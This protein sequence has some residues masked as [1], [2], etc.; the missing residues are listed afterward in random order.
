MDKKAIYH[1]LI[2]RENSKII[3]Q[4]LGKDSEKIRELE[5]KILQRKKHLLL[6]REV[7][8]NLKLLEKYSGESM[9]IKKNAEK[10]KKYILKKIIF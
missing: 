8:R 6:L 2:F 9:L 3:F 7:N 1:Y 10:F 5:K 4:Y